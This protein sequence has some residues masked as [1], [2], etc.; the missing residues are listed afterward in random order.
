MATDHWATDQSQFSTL[1]TVR[2][3]ATC[4]QDCLGV[5]VRFCMHSPL[6]ADGEP[7]TAVMQHR[8]IISPKLRF[9][10]LYCGHTVSFSCCLS[11]EL[12]C[13]WPWLYL[14]VG[15]NMRML[16]T[17]S[18]SECFHCAALCTWC[19]RS[20]FV[21]VA[22][23]FEQNLIVSPGGVAEPLTPSNCSTWK[24][25]NLNCVCASK[26]PTDRIAASSRNLHWSFEC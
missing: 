22:S 8:S 10:L 24:A 11:L 15:W 14:S 6:Q 19:S 5:H 23:C 16:C 3:L 21:C 1:T 17:S 26:M 2:I 7:K 18:D 12:P 20:F 9:F 13:W 25:T 4:S